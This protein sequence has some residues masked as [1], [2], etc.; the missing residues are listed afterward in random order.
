MIMIKNSYLTFRND[1]ISNNILHAW[2]QSIDF[3]TF[4]QNIGAQTEQHANKWC[5]LKCTM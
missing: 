5:G 2:N 1:F 4:R 3:I